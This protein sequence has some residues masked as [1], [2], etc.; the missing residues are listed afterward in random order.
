MRKILF[1]NSNL[2]MCSFASQSGSKILFAP[3]KQ[4]FAPCPTLLNNYQ[5]FPVKLI[6]MIFFFVCRRCFVPKMVFSKKDMICPYFGFILLLLFIFSKFQLMSMKRR[7]VFFSEQT[8]CFWRIMWWNMSIKTVWSDGSLGRR[9][10]WRLKRGR[11]LQVLSIMK[12]INKV[13]SGLF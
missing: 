5:L 2:I 4:K 7:C 10:N 1:R 6:F 11:S 3:K 8:L 13:V 12:I 9:E